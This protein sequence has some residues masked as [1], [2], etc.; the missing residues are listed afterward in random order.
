MREPTR[1]TGFGCLLFLWSATVA[2][3]ILLKLPACIGG[4]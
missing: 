1:G 3:W 4:I 2:V